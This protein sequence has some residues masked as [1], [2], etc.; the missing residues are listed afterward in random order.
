MILIPRGKNCEEKLIEI[1]ESSGWD[2]RIIDVFGT[3]VM[4]LPD[5]TLVP[6]ALRD[7]CVVSRSPLYSRDFRHEDSTVDVSGLTIGGGG[8]VIA[9]GPCAVESEEQIMAVAEG[10]KK[11]GCEML[12]GG[13][14]KPRTSPYSFQGLMERGLDLLARAG[15][16][17]GLL[18][19]SEIMDLSDY[20]EFQKIDML[21]VGARNAQNFSLLKFLGRVKKP[22]LLKNG[23]GTTMEEWLASSEYILSGGNDRVILCY[24]GTRSLERSTRFTMD[25]GTMA[26]VKRR[27]HLPV[28]ADP[29][30]PAGNRE[31]V[32]AM[33]LGAVAAGVDMLEIEAHIEPER[34]LSDA[35]Q[36]VTIEMLRDIVRSARRMHQLL[37]TDSIAQ[38]VHS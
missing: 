38:L 29:S 8:L 7:I 20:R 17:Y 33:A 12:R 14:F 4:A 23:I 27:T 22:V 21:Q 2:G 36:Q 34:A 13:A 26:S 6:D 25:L 30:H 35:D 9:A 1:S 24:R 31:I 18:T 11:A 5:S 3:R 19:V 37:R 32:K 16:E 28:C 15:Q 10:V